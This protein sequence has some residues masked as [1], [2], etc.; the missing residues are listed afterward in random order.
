MRKLLILPIA[1]SVIALGACSTTETTKTETEKKEEKTE[2]VEK[3]EDSNNE[4]TGSGEEEDGELTEVGDTITD[5]LGTQTLKAVATSPVTVGSGDLD[6]TIDRVE[7]IEVENADQT[8]WEMIGINL[9]DY[10][11]IGVLHLDMSIKNN[12]EKRLSVGFAEKLLTSTSQTLDQFNKPGIITDTSEILDQD[13]LRGTEQQGR[14]T[15]V[16]EIDDADEVLEWIELYFYATLDDES[17]E[18]IDGIEDV[19]KVEFDS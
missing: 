12:T 2:A 16:F 14:E 13:M 9:D 10:N 15:Y 11:K 1:A 17:M 8:E 19:V 6:F 18:S 5:K 3:K 4:E 7:Y